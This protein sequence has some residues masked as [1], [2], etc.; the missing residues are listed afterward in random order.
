M[1]HEIKPVM[2]QVPP[3][4]SLFLPFSY[5]RRKKENFDF[6]VC[7][8][9]RSKYTNSIRSRFETKY[10]YPFFIGANPQEVVLYRD[11]N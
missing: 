4:A 1:F 8:L 10:F 11:K 3:R 6:V 2:D 5:Y 7:S 9:K